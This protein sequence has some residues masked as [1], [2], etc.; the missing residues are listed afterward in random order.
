MSQLTT[1]GFDFSGCDAPLVSV[2]CASADE[3]K[4]ARNVPTIV[5]DAIELQFGGVPPGE[6]DKVPHELHALFK[7]RG[8][9][10]DSATP[11]IRVD[12]VAGV[13]AAADD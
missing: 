9:Y 11:V 5:V 6:S 10:R 4:I 2:V 7:P 13:C 8:M 1:E 12:L 3:P